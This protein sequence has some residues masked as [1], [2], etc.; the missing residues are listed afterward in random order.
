[1]PYV[2]RVAKKDCAIDGFNFLAGNRVRL[3]L[4]AYPARGDV[5][6]EAYFGKGRHLCVDKDLSQWVCRT[7]VYE[8]AKIPL[9]VRI[10]E[11]RLR[12]HD[13]AFNMYDS[14][15]VSIDG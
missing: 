4:D 13:F 12:S 7:L 9:H 3:F 1:V 8:L 5:K 14:I 15:E 11:A 2:E 10:T 6:R